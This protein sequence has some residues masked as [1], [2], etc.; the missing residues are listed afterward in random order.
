MKIN[1]IALYTNDLEQ[2]KSFYLKYFNAS[3]NQGYHNPNTGLRTYFL[4]F[5]DHTRLEIM[6]R[7]NLNQITP[8]PLQ[9]GYIHLAFSAG[10]KEA[11]DQL[12]TTLEQDGYTVLSKPRT[13]GDGYYE[14]CVLD[15]DGN[16]IEIVE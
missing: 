8:V 6:N 15:P 2:M 14:S 5:E 12:T 1:H 13:T 10:S 16:Q 3:S 7:P 9:T 11:V 4:S